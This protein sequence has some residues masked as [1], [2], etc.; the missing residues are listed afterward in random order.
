MPSATACPGAGT[1]CRVHPERRQLRR[2]GRE[3]DRARPGRTRC[4][5]APKRTGRAR[6]ANSFCPTSRASARRTTIRMSRGVSLRSRPR[7]R[8]RRARRR[9]CW[10]ASPSRLRD[11]LDALARERRP[12]STAD[13]DR[14]RRPL[15]LLG[16]HLSAALETAR[17]SIA[18]RRS[19]PGAGRRAAGAHGVHRRA[20]R[21]DLRP[22]ADCAVVE[23]DAAPRRLAALAATMRGLLQAYSVDI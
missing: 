14:R 20:R 11:G 2:L 1:R 9:R 7:H 17:S 13:R 19:R 10:K 12:R 18:R 15:A 22:A 21:R 23:P 4:S 6:A 16:P 3:A 8:R 5:A